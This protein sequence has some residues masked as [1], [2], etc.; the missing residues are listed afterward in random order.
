[1]RHSSFPL[2]IALVLSAA[3]CS[4]AAAPRESG[5]PVRVIRL[6]PEPYSLTYFS[7]LDESQRAVVRDEA[8]WRGAW[9]AIWRRHSPEPPLPQVDFDREMLV[10]AALGTRPTT[11]YGILV[12]SAFAE[13]DGLLVRIRTV[14][15]GPRCGTGQALTQPVDV[16]RL[17][18][19][20][21]VV[22]FRD[23]PQVHDC[24]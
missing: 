12:D 2:L 19:T 7:G 13:G 6:R 10:I 4:Q 18:R 23:E 14:T 17:T 8:A 20:Q 5:S 22:R 9:A 11:G 16:A 3:A 1:M 21:G 15:P 24:P